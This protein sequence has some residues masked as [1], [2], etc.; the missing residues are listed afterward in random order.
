VGI[1]VHRKRSQVVVVTEDGQVQLN[2]SCPGMAGGT[3]QARDN[4]GQALPRHGAVD[5]HE[6]CQRPA[7]ERPTSCSR[8]GFP[9]AET[10]VPD[11]PR[12]TISGVTV[13]I[14]APQP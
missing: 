2:E 6:I 4:I 10:E 8:A 3:G 5:R 12:R 7:T 14:P 11:L 9:A 1:D 13:G